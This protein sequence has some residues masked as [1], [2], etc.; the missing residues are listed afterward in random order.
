[1]AAHVD[2]LVDVLDHHRAR[3]LARPADVAGPQHLVRDHRPDDVLAHLG[4]LGAVAVGGPPE[5]LLDHLVGVRIEIVAQVEEELPRSERLSG[6][7]RRALR[8]AAPALR[9]AEHVEH[10][11]PGEVV[12]VRAP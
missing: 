5:P 10:L 4:Q 3:L 8:G 7:R 11:L 9:A 12:D 2:D 1:M 6:R